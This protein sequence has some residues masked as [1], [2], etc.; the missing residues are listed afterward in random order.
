MKTPANG[1]GAAVPS[2]SAAT[3]TAETGSAEKKTINVELWQA[4]AGPLVNLPAA[5]THVVY[6]P[7]GHSEQVNFSKLLH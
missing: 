3:T 6:F 1:A 7:Q 4:C 5:G 2:S